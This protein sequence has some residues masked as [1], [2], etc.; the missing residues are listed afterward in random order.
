[1]NILIL[2]GA[3]FIGSRLAKALA[4]RQHDVTVLDNLSQQIHG[5]DA[6]FAD[7]LQAVA[8]CVRADIRDRALLTQAVEGQ[9]VIVNYAA[10]TGTGQ[11][12]YAAIMTMMMIIMMMKMIMILKII[13]IT[14]Y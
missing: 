13:S 11:S 5:A 9:E 14:D 2:G 1:M 8:R 6:G 12:M 7:D 10:E 4:A 3:G